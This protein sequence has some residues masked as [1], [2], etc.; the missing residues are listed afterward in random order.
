MSDPQ[1]DGPA[2]APRSSEALYTL[3]GAAFDA[4]DGRALLAPLTL[5]LEAG[6]M[7]ALIGHNGSGKSTLVKMLARQ[8]APSRG[9]VQLL[10]RDLAA[11]P[12]R[13]FARRI[14]YLPQH[15]PAATDMT[16]R[17][18][19]ALGRYPWHGALGRLSA[20]DREKIDEALELTDTAR[21]ASQLADRLSGGE[22]QRVW[23][24]MLV[25]QGA[26]CLL[27]DEPTSALDIAHQIDV[28]RLLRT[29]ADTRG[30]TVVI[31]L[32]DINLAARFSDELI[33]LHS[34]RL[35]ARGTPQALMHADT[36]ESI[37]GIPMDVVA[38]PRGGWLGVAH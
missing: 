24:A 35:L 12:A 26:D 31:V 2:A 33:A 38:H 5:T 13:E 3:E 16:V 10:G 36:L 34:G 37:Y 14:A 4:A 19:V 28:L 1:R 27:L 7:S 22:R 23:L 9:R 15:P 6:R 25:A 11:W 17:E 29:L 21:F 30:L 32:H 20:T 8:Q 18:L